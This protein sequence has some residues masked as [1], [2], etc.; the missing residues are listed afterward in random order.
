MEE[1][2]ICPEEP[3]T[4]GTLFKV[5]RR[6]LE[7]YRPVIPE[8]LHLLLQAYTVLLQEGT[9]AELLTSKAINAVAGKVEERLEMSIENAMSKMSSMVDSLVDNQEKVQAS[10]TALSK[11]AETFKKLMLNMDTVAVMPPCYD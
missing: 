7:K 4:L 6:I 3:V 1:E 9:G 11:T 8:D 10:T 5:F 2:C